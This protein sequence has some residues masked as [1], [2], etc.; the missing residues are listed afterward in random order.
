MF[1]I[2]LFCVAGAFLVI[3]RALYYSRTL[4]ETKSFLALAVKER[5]EEPNREK[6]SGNP[7][8][9]ILSAGLANHSLHVEEVEAIMRET[10]LDELPKMERHLSTIAIIGSTLPML[11]LLGTVVGMITTF[12]VIAVKG[13]GDPGFLSGGIS[14]ALI[15]TETGLV[16]AIPFLFFHNYLNNKYN[17]LVGLVEK[18]SSRILS[19]VKSSNRSDLKNE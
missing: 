15:T 6:Y 5:K 1:P 9:K 3:D 18:E 8:V 4:K 10:A 11:G 14:Q 7:I 12:E 19:M 13:T 17:R 16:A 2:A